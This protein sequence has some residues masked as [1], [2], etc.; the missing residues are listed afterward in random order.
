M[1]IDTHCFRPLEAPETKF[2]G[3]EGCCIKREFGNR[4]MQT[5]VS[6]RCFSIGYS[7]IHN[8]LE[9]CN[10]WGN[11]DKPPNNSCPTDGRSSPITEVCPIL[12]VAE[13]T[14]VGERSNPAIVANVVISMVVD[15]QYNDQ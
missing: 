13:R 3:I 6:D 7:L 8:Q 15:Y 11:R 4:W 14:R 10:D 12:T 9:S 5:Q 2:G 1:S